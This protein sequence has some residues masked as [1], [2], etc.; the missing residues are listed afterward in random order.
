MEINFPPKKG[1]GLEKLLPLG[2]PNDVKDILLKL[3]IY[4]PNERITAEQ[5]LKHDY[6]A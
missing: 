3:L 6:F 4:D 1:I 2:C 5:A